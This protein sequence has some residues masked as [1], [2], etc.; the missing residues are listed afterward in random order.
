MKHPRFR[1]TTF[2]CKPH[3][4]DGRECKDADL[5]SDKTRHIYTSF[6]PL[7]NILGLQVLQ[8]TVYVVSIAHGDGLMPKRE[9]KTRK[10]ISRAGFTLL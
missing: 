8:L 9:E 1:V 5:D 10:Y 7:T 2:R 4:S 3:C 6:D